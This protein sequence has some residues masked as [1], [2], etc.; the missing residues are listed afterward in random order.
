M[1]E[2]VNYKIISRRKPEL[3]GHKV[4]RTGAIYYEAW[5]W[6]GHNWNYK[7]FDIRKKATEFVKELGIEV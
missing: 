2:L 1:K 6:N 7:E 3:H 4:K 5:Y